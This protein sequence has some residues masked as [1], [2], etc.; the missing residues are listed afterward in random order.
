[1]TG[2][3]PLS[4]ANVESLG[5]LVGSDATASGDAL[6][7]AVAKE[8]AGQYARDEPKARWKGKTTARSST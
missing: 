1:M 2:G 6:V 8:L 7:S 3:L 5:G 4:R